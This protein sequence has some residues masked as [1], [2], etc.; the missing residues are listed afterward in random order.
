MSSML[1][2]Y[3]AS[4]KR[5][6]CVSPLLDE[7]AKVFKLFIQPLQVGAKSRN[8]ANLK[9]KLPSWIKVPT[10]V[11]IPFGV[12]EKVLEDE[13]NKV[14]GL[15]QSLINTI[16]EIFGFAIQVPTCSYLCIVCSL[17]LGW[18]HQTD[19]FLCKCRRFPPRFR[20]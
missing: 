11:A 19:G 9:R 17:F 15:P 13:R 18:V 1:S 4:Q 8:I 12:F 14:S 10:S 5:Y 20:V 6:V 16:V 3:V 7:H 2:L